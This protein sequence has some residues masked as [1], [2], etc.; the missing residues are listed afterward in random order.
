MTL[1]IVFFSADSSRLT[2][3]NPLSALMIHQQPG[4][5]ICTLVL[6]HTHSLSTSNSITSLSTCDTPA[7][8]GT[9]VVL[10]CTHWQSLATTPLSEWYS[11]LGHVTTSKQL[12]LYIHQYYSLSPTLHI[13][14]N[15][16]NTAT[17]AEHSS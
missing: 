1:H 15:T 5:T 10:N 3:C 8:I 7:T 14:N 2:A 13:I 17:S 11:C 9:S 4:S 16:A 12:H 6:Q